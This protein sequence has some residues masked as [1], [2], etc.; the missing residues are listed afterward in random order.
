MFN[1]SKDFAPPFKLIAPFFI[2]GA[3]FYILSSL[4]LL[5]FKI[6]FDYMQLNIAGWIH[7]F[8]LGFVMTIIFGAMAQL[9]PVILETGHF[10][11]DFYYIIFPLLLIGTILMVFGFWFNPILLSFGGILVLSSML[12]FA[13]EVF[14]TIKKS[15][16]KTFSTKAIKVSNIFL[17]IGI[18]IGFLISLTI[19]GFLGF[20]IESLIKAHIYA[21]VGGYI[22]ITIMG[23]TLIL[24]PM[25][26]LAHG[27][28][29]KPIN[30]AMN[31][32]II[33][34]VFVIIGSFLDL[35]ILMELGYIGS[36]IAVIFYLYQIYLIQKVRMR[37]ESDIW[38]KSMVVA[39]VSLIVSAILGFFYLLSTDFRPLLYGSIWFLFIGFFAFLINGHL[40][41]I[42]PFLVWFHRYSEL[43]GKEKVPMLKD[44]YPKKEADFEF[45]FSLFGLIVAGIGL[46]TK[47]ETLFKAGVSFLFIGSIFLGTSIKWMLNYG[48]K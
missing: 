44:M 47:E 24:L 15:S 18:L 22:M 36:F 45:Y 1:I 33:S 23:I 42:I 41:K 43:V 32:M 20:D 12:I 16:L 11:V 13:T 19:S 10:S 17:L 4:A 39:F 34:I 8:L 28:D 48:K 25:F 29:E 14:L 27:F 9:V 30:K 21:V 40:Y 5:F 7:L 35:K 6:D 3:I 2:S 26:G 38:S 37:K 31:I 46:L